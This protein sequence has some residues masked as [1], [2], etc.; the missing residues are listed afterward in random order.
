MSGE[1]QGSRLEQ[2]PNETPRI[3]VASLSDYNAGRLH[4]A[5]LDADTSVEDLE[6]GVSTM[7][8]ASS[9]PGA[10]EFA[11]HD[12]EN[13]GP[14]RLSEYES[15]STVSTLARGIAEHGQAFA[16]WAAHQD[17]LLEAEAD[18]FADAFQG[19]WEDRQAYAEEMFESFG[20]DVDRLPSLPDWLRPYVRIDTEAW[21][22]DAELNGDLNVIEHPGGIWVFT[23]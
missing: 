14:I 1:Q 19:D 20:I 8:A 3:Y 7:L 4:G 21:L 11:I 22:R 10:E 16:A 12:F 6:A 9:E 17:S 5:W 18:A 2:Q 23:S 13:F 15:L